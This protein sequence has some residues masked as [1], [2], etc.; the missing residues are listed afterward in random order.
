MEKH[1][2]T[3]LK[4]VTYAAVNN[5][6]I[7]DS[8][9]GKTNFRYCKLNRQVRKWLQVYS[10]NIFAKG[11]TTLLICGL[12]TVKFSLSRAQVSRFLLLLSLSFFSFIGYLNNFSRAS[13][14]AVLYT[15]CVGRVQRGRATRY[16]GLLPS[17]ESGI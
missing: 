1:T 17:A 15:G 10:E 12:R 13:A 2:I 7:V 9:P 14:F 3:F 16:A 6:V 5:G 11:K 4:A 8:I